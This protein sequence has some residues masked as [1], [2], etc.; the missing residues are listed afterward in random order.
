MKRSK[1]LN[2]RIH[3]KK[4][5]LERFDLDLNRDDLNKIKYLIQNKKTLM[6][7]RSSLRVTIHRVDYKGKRMRVVYDKL[8]KNIVTFLPMEDHEQNRI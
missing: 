3:A 7:E 4:R 1:K 6:L 5:A 2:Q 8:R